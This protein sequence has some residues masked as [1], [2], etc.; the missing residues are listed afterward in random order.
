MT[1][2]AV[3]MNSVRLCYASNNIG[4]V[5]LRIYSK[6]EESKEIERLELT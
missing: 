5:E 4:I 6:L 3:C 1:D 2:G